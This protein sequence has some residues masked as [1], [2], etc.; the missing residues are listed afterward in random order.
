[1]LGRRRRLKTTG[2]RI[3]HRLALDLMMTSNTQ[4]VIAAF[5]AQMSFLL[6]TPT[7]HFGICKSTFSF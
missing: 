4:L 6:F 5:T 7:T 2:K 1:M 3:A